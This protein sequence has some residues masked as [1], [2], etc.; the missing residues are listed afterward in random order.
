MQTIECVLWHSGLKCEV[1]FDQGGLSRGRLPYLVIGLFSREFVR[2]TPQ[3]KEWR[4]R[5]RL[6]SKVEVLCL[7]QVKM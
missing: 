6:L 7:R 3:T 1:A 4:V 2:A 5:S